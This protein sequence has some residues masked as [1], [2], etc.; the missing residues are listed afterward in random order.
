[1]S[2]Q[3]EDKVIQKVKKLLRLANSDNKNEA[4]LAT[5][6]ANEL[7]KSHN[8]EFANNL[9]E[10]GEETALVRVLNCRRVNG[11]LQA[12]YKIM[13]HFFVAPVFSYGESN[14]CIELIG[15]KHNVA[16]AEYVAIFLSNALENLYDQ[17]R[18]AKGISGIRAK[19]SFMLGA[20]DGFIKK[21]SNEEVRTHD[22]KELVLL[23]LQ[24]SKHFKRVYPRCQKSKRYIIDEKAKRLGFRSGQSLSV[25]PAITKKSTQ[26]FLK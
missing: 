6:K 4:E 2:S 18:E 15:E 26:K 10:S 11:R 1:M 9:E 16:C 3:K 17:S 12:I 20:A 21:I 7:I 5:A 24:I 8:I 14:V 25:S 13:H 19:N 22:T 23:Q